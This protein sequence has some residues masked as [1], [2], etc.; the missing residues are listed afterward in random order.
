V[1]G[2]IGRRAAVKGA[3]VASEPRVGE[4]L[5]AGGGA[6]VDGG[7]RRWGGRRETAR[8]REVAARSSLT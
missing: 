4:L 8:E 3:A 7:L 1:D 6:A 2:E 5:S